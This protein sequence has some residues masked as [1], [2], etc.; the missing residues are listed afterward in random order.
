MDKKKKMKENNGRYKSQTFRFPKH[1]IILLELNLRLSKWQGLCFVV[2]SDTALLLCR[3]ADPSGYIKNTE[4]ECLMTE[5]CLY[6]F[7]VLFSILPQDRI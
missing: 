6:C 4:I 2:S 7:T 5:M 1:F 3:S